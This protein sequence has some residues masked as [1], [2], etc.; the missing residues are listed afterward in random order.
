MHTI[1]LR[2]GKYYAHHTFGASVGPCRGAVFGA[3]AGVYFIGNR[4]VLGVHALGQ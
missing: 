2:S 3:F 4:C 1:L